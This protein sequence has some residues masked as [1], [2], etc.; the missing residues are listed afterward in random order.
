[1]NFFTTPLRTWD[2][3]CLARPA[4]HPTLRRYRESTTS[5]PRACLTAEH[6]SSRGNA[7][8]LS[9]D[10]S[11]LASRRPTAKSEILLL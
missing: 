5:K 6:G 10:N 8:G 4:R 1:M 3:L 7:R 11:E 2:R 9:R